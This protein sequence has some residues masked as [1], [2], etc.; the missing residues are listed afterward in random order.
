MPVIAGELDSFTPTHLAEQMATTIP[1]SELVVV[2]KG[3]HVMP[4]KRRKQVL[5]R[6]RTFIQ[7][8]TMAP[9]TEQ[10][11]ADVPR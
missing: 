1:N 8:R 4:I 3:T 6:V 11:N 5:A 9:R 2:D 7:T 10:Q